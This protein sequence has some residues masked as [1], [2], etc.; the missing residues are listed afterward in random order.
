MGQV[1]QAEIIFVV[2]NGT[3]D[4]SSW[5]TATNLPTALAKAT[6]TTEIWVAQGV[7]T[8][9]ATTNR[10]ATFTLTDGVQLYGGFFGNET[11]RADRKPR[12]RE[13]VLS[14]EIG[15]PTPADNSYTVVHIVNASAAT[16]LDGFTISDGNANG[17]TGP[18][19][20]QRCGG[21][22]F[23]TGT[24]ASS[25]SI[26]NCIIK[27]NFAREGGAVYNY[28]SA[29]KSNPAIVKCSFINN[30]AGLDGGAIY[31][32]GKDGESNPSL[33]NCHFEDNL[34]NYGAGIFC[35]PQNGT[36]ALA[37]SNC[38][39]KNNQAFMWG[40]GIYG[41]KNKGAF[42]Y[43]LK[44]CEFNNNYPTDINKEVSFG[45]ISSANSNK[46]SR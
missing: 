22:I 6:A 9:T 46:G 37:L 45:D 33:V 38:T 13:T 34:A 41:D 7:H 44:D 18:G 43:N 26:S 32:D 35:N 12:F 2:P 30:Q 10:E 31:N 21:G 25:P 4:G 1:G 3:G 20:M 16:V 15:N 23:N 36:S 24:V 8:P 11:N 17:S 28:G 5:A 42:S 29:G 27:D 39:F 19:T 14:G 40:G